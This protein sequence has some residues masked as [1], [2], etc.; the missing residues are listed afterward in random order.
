MMWRRRCALSLWKFW[1]S[2]CQISGSH[3][4]KLELSRSQG[5][6]GEFSCL[7]AAERGAVWLSGPPCVSDRKWRSADSDVNVSQEREREREGRVK[8]WRG[9]DWICLKCVIFYSFSGS[10]FYF[11]CLLEA[12]SLFFT[13]TVHCYSTSIH[14]LAERS[15]LVPVPFNPPSWIAQSAL[16]GQLL[17]AWAGTTHS[18]VSTLPQRMFPQRWLCCGRAPGC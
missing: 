13:Y 12:L 11:G 15:V 10:C 1:Q 16:T 6:L 2:R 7:P 8:V 17:H 9:Q 14:S 5:A 3:S 4:I 18:C